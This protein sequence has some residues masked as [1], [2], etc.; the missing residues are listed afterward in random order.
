MTGDGRDGG[1]I[2]FEWRF[3]VLCLMWKRGIRETADVYI[4]YHAVQITAMRQ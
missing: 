2:V 4:V 3:Y 1:V